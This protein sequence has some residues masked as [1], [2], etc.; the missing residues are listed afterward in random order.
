MLR[1]YFLQQWFNLSDP[2]VEET[3]YDSAVMRQF[4]G[5]DLGCEPVPDETTVCKFRN[6]LEDH[7][8][9][10][11][12][13][14]T[15]NLHLQARGVRITTGTIVD[16]TILHAPS[17]T[18]NREQQ[19]DPE[20]QQTKK[21]NQWYFGMKAHVYEAALLELDRDKLPQRITE[22]QHAVMDRMRVLNGRDGGSESEALMNALNAL[23]D[24]QKMA[25]GDGETKCFGRTPR[26][27]P[28]RVTADCNG[29]NWLLLG[30]WRIALE[31]FVGRCDI[32]RPQIVEH[33]HPPPI[34]QIQIAHNNGPSQRDF[35]YKLLQVEAL[36]KNRQRWNCAARNF[37]RRWIRT[38]RCMTNMAR[39]F[40]EILTNVHDMF[41]ER[42][43][44]ALGLG[45]PNQEVQI[46][47]QSLY[48]LGS[49]LGESRHVDPTIMDA[50]Q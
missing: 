32:L 30:L 8:L 43:L 18:K 20:M 33:R 44:L 29:Q 42:N 40:Y 27:T 36:C 19:R 49:E 21:G 47:D 3:L 50:V 16:A 24:L 46:C 34:T 4:V 41:V 22:A 35:L 6:P 31:I 28:G 5:I 9:G 2:A 23:R 15:V 17:S 26:H 48:L 11:Q 39:A 13:L 38:G 45:N 25:D 12:I 37:F 14:G 1:I 10:E 7:Q